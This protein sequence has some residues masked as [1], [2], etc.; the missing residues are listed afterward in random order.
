MKKMKYDI[1][2]HGRFI[3]H[4]GQQIRTP[5]SVETNNKKEIE[6]LEFFLHTNCIKYQKH[7]V[8]KNEQKQEK[9]VKQLLDKQSVQ[10][11]KKKKKPVTIL[12]KLAVGEKIEGL[13]NEKN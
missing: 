2:G 1:E 4:K 3:I 10:E 9:R 6:L 13:N 12:E 7:L 8:Q 5:C 11:I